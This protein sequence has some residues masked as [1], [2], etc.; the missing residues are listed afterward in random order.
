[1]G[2]RRK[3]RELAL[4]LLFQIEMSGSSF[5]EAAV[6]FSEHFDLNRKSVAYGL[7]LVQGVVG[8]LVEID[9]LIGK[10]AVNWRLE[11]MSHIDRNI[12]RLAVFE[13]RYQEEVPPLVVINEAI[14]VAKL[15]GTKESPSFVNGVLDAIKKKVLAMNRADDAGD[16]SH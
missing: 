16:G 15:Y 7:K 6:L 12:I 9:G 1:M 10:Y 2:T 13:L 11:R 14:E 5:S 8:K 4:Q 3:S